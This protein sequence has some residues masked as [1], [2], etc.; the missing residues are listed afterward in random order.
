MRNLIFTLSLLLTAATASFAQQA[1]GT[2]QIGLLAGPNHTFSRGAQA[3]IPNE[4]RIEGK[5]AV[6]GAAGVSLQYQ[7]RKVFIKTNLLYENKSTKTQYTVFPSNSTGRPPGEQLLRENRHYLTVPLLVGVHIKNTG[8]FV[9]AGPYASLLL[10][11]TY[12]LEGNTKN[13]PKENNVDLGFSVGIGYSRAI[14]PRLNIS[15]EARHNFSIYNSG[16]SSPLNGKTN[17]T[18]LLFGVHYN[19]T[20]K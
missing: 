16:S 10:K 5:A 1:V 18:S 6:N 8:F 14:T 12:E 4:Q 15:A 7:F 20:G 3:E 9:N 13:Y 11:H 17:S 2:L 19:L